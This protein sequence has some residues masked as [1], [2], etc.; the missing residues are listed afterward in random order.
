[1]SRAETPKERMAMLRDAPTAAPLP[2][3]LMLDFELFNRSYFGG[4][5]PRPFFRVGRREIPGTGGWI[6]GPPYL[7][8]YAITFVPSLFAGGRLHVRDVLLHELV[9]LAVMLRNP[10]D[11][12]H[13]A[14][15]LA[16]ANRVGRAIGLRPAAPSDL[17]SW[18]HTVRP[19]GFYAAAP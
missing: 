3:W 7:S 13:D 8:E 10:G 6:D 4:E 11:R 18:P 15:F 16:E 19:D 2:A 1:M 14:L 9:H 17:L 12:Q 5:L